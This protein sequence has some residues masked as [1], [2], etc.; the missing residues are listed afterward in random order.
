MTFEIEDN[1]P[2]PSR[3]GYPFAEMKVSQ[4]FFV[5]TTPEAGSEKAVK[6]RSLFYAWRKWTGRVDELGCLCRE[7]EGGVRFWLLSADDPK[8]PKKIGRP[9]SVGSPR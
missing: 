7:V 9:R 6:I 2:L 5:P 1:V 4:S 8:R 3:W